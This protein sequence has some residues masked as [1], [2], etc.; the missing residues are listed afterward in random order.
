M[1]HFSVHKKWICNET[2]KVFPRLLVDDDVQ[3]EQQTTKLE[4]EK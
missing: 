1:F 2:F 4:R 3:T